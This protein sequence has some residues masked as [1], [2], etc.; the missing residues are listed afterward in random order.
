MIS[1]VIIL[2]LLLPIFVEC[3]YLSCYISNDPTYDK[4]QCTDRQVPQPSD[5]CFTFTP[6]NG[7]AESFSCDPKNSLCANVGVGCNNDSFYNNSNGTVCC[8]KSDLC[9]IGRNHA[10]LLMPSSTKM[11]SITI[12]LVVVGHFSA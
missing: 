6:N 5:Y 3:D 11:I 9:N 2:I 7:E 10:N 12:V 4:I 1:P 8:C